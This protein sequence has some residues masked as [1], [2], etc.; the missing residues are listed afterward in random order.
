[1]NAYKPA[2]RLD[3]VRSF[4]AVA[5]ALIAVAATGCN[6]GPGRSLHD[7]LSTVRG[8]RGHADAEL[9]G[10]LDSTAPPANLRDY[11]HR[12]AFRIIAAT[13]TKAVPR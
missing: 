5:V 3:A 2:N 6:A 11:R 9:I 4:G 10:A 1:M 13:R 8:M 7:G 12:A